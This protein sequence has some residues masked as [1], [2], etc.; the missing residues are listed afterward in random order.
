MLD[1]LCASMASHPSITHLVPWR[2]LYRDKTTCSR[3]ESISPW[4]GIDTCLVDNSLCNHDHSKCAYHRQVIILWL[5]LKR[6]LTIYTGILVWRIWRVEK[7][8]EKISAYGTEPR[9]LRRVI[10]VILESGTVYTLMVCT[11]TSLSMAGSHALYPVYNMVSDRIGKRDW[12]L[13]ISRN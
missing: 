13:M 10:R 9:P 6:W 1:R 2:H 5:R 11:C 8:S 3:M 7:Q 4:V 12:A